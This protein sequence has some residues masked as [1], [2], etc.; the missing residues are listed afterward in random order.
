MIPK[1]L[2]ELLR[3]SAQK[4]PRRTAIV[5][6]RKKISY[7]AL[8]EATDQIACGLIEAGIREQ[9]RVAL[10]LDN[11]PEFIISYYAVLKAGAVT[12][13]INYMF[14]VEEAKY[15][16]QDSEAVAIIASR[17]YLDI[18]EELRLRVD[19]LKL[20]ISTSKA[21]D[22]IIYFEG[23]K[24]KETQRLSGASGNPEDLAVILY[25]S[26]T[27]GHPKGAMLTHSNLVSNAIDSASAIKSSYKDAFICILPLFHSFAATV[28]MNLPLLVGAKIVVMKSL[29]PFKRVIRAIR[30]NKVTVFVGIPS[31]YNILKDLKLPAFM[32]TALIR[33]FNPVKVCISGAAALPA[34]TLS[35]FEKRF[36]IP[37][38][39][40]Y[41]LTEASPVVTL[42][43]LRGQR[44]PGSI[45]VTLS[46]TI[47]LKIV[48]EKDNVLGAGEIGELIVRGPNIMRGYLKQEEA[49]AE[50][51][52]DDW[53]YTGDMAKFDHQGY[54][55]IVGRKKEMV[56]VRGLNVYPREIEEVLYS[57]PKIKEA[58][59]IGITDT[60]KGE[61][62]KAFVVLKEGVVAKEQEIIHY[63]RERL[64]P[65]KIP[66]FV[67]FRSS[68]P[69]NATGKILKRILE[70]EEEKR[71]RPQT[72]P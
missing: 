7:K 38:L 47:E 17:P 30:K 51:I 35:G 10:F 67:E 32:N 31:I 13:P 21:K 2:A 60:H 26:G 71:Q 5:F 19:S 56:N 12:V 20:I 70:D 1:N 62:P 33:I 54:F 18:A 6:G 37:L 29:R 68:L 40:G 42:N 3:N 36:R 45:G 24:K 55:I 57:N 61:V 16:L 65:Y 39:E 15:I 64:A 11:C 23:L 63:L 4:H 46:R 49:S 22:H 69:K 9:Q 14:K 27:T 52:R 44:K 43:P 8:D 48:D 72:P 34:E 58:A 25:T 59:V 50:T 53:L 28:C 66:K 41:G